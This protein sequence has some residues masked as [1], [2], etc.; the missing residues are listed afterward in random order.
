MFS[1]ACEYAIRSVIFVATSSMKGERVGF[2]EIAKEVGAPE[3]FTAKILQKL[4]KSGIILSIKGVGG[5]FEIPVEG[6]KEIKLCEI[7]NVIDGDSI[8]KGCGLGLPKCSE[9][10]PCP[11]HEKFKEIRENLRQMLETTTIEELSMGI[12]SGDTFLK[13]Q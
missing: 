3:A 4:A 6:L 10:H 1:K 8:Y 9:T 2:K 7:V 11:V 5:G 13:I 12:K